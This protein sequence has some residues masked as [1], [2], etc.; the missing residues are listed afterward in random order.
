MLL[1]CGDS[2]QHRGVLRRSPDRAAN[3]NTSRFP[4]TGVH[5]PPPGGSGSEL[6]HQLRRCILESGLTTP[7]T[8]TK[9]SHV[10]GVVP[11]WEIMCKMKLFPVAIVVPVVLPTYLVL[12]NLE[13]DTLFTSYMD[14]LDAKLYKVSHKA[15]ELT[16][17]I[18]NGVAFKPES[19]DA[20]KTILYQT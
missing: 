15:S 5:H 16:S 2:N 18:A 4:C 12:V 6:L 11:C 10:K 1:A 3:T 9:L 8:R 20:Y 13:T 14:I 17:A 19:T 7:T